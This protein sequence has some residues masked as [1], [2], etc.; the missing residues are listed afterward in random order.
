MKKDIQDQ[1]LHR[2]STNNLYL[3]HII[4]E[5]DTVGPT[6]VDLERQ[7]CPQKDWLKDNGGKGGSIENYK[8]IFL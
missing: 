1:R 3:E 4:A 5:L 7:D 2:N 8:V 6:Y